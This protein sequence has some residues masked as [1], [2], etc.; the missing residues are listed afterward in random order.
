MEIKGPSSSCRARGV[1]TRS[2]EHTHEF[3]YLL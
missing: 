3:F 1:K 2:A